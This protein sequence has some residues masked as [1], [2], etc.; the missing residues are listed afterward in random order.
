[1]TKGQEETTENV[2]DTTN[3]NETETTTDLTTTTTEYPITVACITDNTVRYNKIQS[4]TILKVSFLLG[5]VSDTN[6]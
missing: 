2:S 3:N 6:L 5:N 1:M 4:N